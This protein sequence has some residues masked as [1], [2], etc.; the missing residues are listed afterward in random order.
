MTDKVYPVDKYTDHQE[1]LALV[2]EQNAL[3]AAA[4]GHP[5]RA[6][7]QT[8]GCQ[9]SEE[10]GSKILGVLLDTGMCEARSQEDADL[11]IYNTCCVR[12]NAEQKVYGKLGVLKK[13]KETRP[14]MIIGIMGCM[15]QQQTVV[16]ELTRSYRHVDLI[17]GTGNINLLPD[18][19]LRVMTGKGRVIELK[20]TERTP[21]GTPK[22]THS[23]LKGWVTIMYGCNNFCSYCIVP[24]VRG[25][26]RSRSEEDILDEIRRM[27]ASGTREATLL[28]QNVNSYGSE[29]GL[30]G[31]QAFA[32][33]LRDVCR[34][35][36]LRRV[37]FMTSHPKDLSDDIIAAV[38]E[39]PLLC[40][41]I[42]LPLQSGC[43][44]I[45]RQMNRKYTADQYYDLLCRIRE[46]I[47]GVTVS[48]DII[49]G[50]P[51]ET[52]AQHAESMEFI[53]RC[54]FDMA[55]IFIYSRRAGTPAAKREDQV[56]EETKHR[57]F[58]ELQSIITDSTFASSFALEGETVEVM[59]EGPSSSDPSVM[60]G[61]TDGNR[62][63]MY[64]GDFRPGDMLRVHIDK[65]RTWYLEG[66]VISE[67]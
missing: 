42:H 13:L 40:K 14:H 63:V 37:R 50:F 62:I 41:H 35:P 38:A 52:D 26:E 34:V 18:M 56:P 24:Y 11:V 53:R 36:G 45:L 29:R 46:A 59:H 54:G 17:S 9:M 5:R 61:R 27:V 28:G 12:E 4:F 51:G 55:Y 23:G 60:T 15:T 25:R 57:R 64:R 32:K 22:E 48:T 6:F 20:G 47:P 39:E 19:L 1:A 33:L 67:D 30:P 49:T 21:E 66:T 44:E 16:E 3:F 65:A 43:T 58:N 8:F 10:E 7:V 2:R 31:G